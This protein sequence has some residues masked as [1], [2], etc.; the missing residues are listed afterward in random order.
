MQGKSPLKSKTIWFN[1]LTLLAT[2]LTAVADHTLITEYPVLAPA[3]AVASA[4]VN[5][6]LRLVTKEP[7]K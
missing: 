5:L 4:L 1:V 2:S 3:V 7:I 6:G